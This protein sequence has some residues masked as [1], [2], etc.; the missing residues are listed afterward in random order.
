MK[1]TVVVDMESI[2]IAAVGDTPEDKYGIYNA[3]PSILQIEKM[4]EW[5]KKG[6]TILIECRRD[7]DEDYEVT[8]QWLD[9][10]QVPHSDAVI[11]RVGDNPQHSFWK[12]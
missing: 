11:W 12:N 5:Q 3:Q 6:Y 4:L 1:P 8:H 2:C 10:Y 9:H 7:V